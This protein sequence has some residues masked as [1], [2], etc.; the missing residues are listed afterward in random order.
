MSYN[1][2]KVKKES[3]PARPSN[4]EVPIC[5]VVPQKG[6]HLRDIIL[7]EKTIPTV[8]DTGSSV[9]LFREDVCTKIVD[10]QELSKKYIVL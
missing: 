7:G 4:S 3:E 10:Q 5:S 8:T 1:C 6:L 2:P 9:S